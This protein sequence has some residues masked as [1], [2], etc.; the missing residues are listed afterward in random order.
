MID[1]YMKYVL[2]FTYDL[3]QK[4]ELFCYIRTNSITH[5][6]IKRNKKHSLSGS[7]EAIRSTDC[8]IERKLSSTVE[9]K[10]SKIEALENSELT[11]K[12]LG[13]LTSYLQQRH[14]QWC[15]SFLLVKV[16]K[17]TKAPCL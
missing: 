10:I 16:H 5:K 9:S 15:L 17:E 6:V 2:N 8:T 11:T 3:E 4:Y 12:I 14:H 7:S 13:L 1:V